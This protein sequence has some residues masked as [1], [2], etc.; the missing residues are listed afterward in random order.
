M[1]TTLTACI[2]LPRLQVQLAI[3][4][5]GITRP[6][7]IVADTVAH[8]RVLECCNHA[9]AYGVTPGM[10]ALHAKQRCPSLTLT[11]L[12]P[13][14]IA[15]AH[16]T[17]HSVLQHFGDSAARITNAC[18]H[19]TLR[20]LGPAYQHAR[21]VAKDLQCALR[22]AT[23]LCSVVVLSAEPSIAHLLA[24]YCDTTAERVQIILPG[25]EAVAIAPLPVQHLPGIGIKTAER[26]YQLG[27]GTIGDLAALPSATLAAVFGAR[28]T[29]WQHVAQGRGTVRA[30]SQDNPWNA[31]WHYGVRGCADANQLHRHMQ[32]LTERLG[33]HVR[34]QAHA[35]GTITVTLHW[36]DGRSGTRTEH[37]PGRAMLD[38]DLAAASR[39]LLDQLLAQRRIAVHSL[40]VCVDDYGP[41][42]TTLFAPDPRIMHRQQAVDQIKQR[43]G[44]DAIQLAWMIQ[45]PTPM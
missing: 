31:V 4:H 23:R 9:S 38:R 29:T 36:T 27:V 45:P 17:T 19:V 7:A 12:A 20:A 8:A 18:W 2:Y 33:R 34:A 42:Q 32:R 5:I 24:Q 16:T 3:Q 41:Q 14:I 22:D 28:G 6:C 15:T 13:S 26:L 43:H 35:A 37:L 25:D 21:T 39:R 30:K 40:T 1:T 44:T 10:P 11:L